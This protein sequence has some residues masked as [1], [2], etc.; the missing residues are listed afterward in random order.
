M[1][2]IAAHLKQREHSTQQ[3]HFS[4]EPP[5]KKHTEEYLRRGSA[6]SDRNEEAME[7]AC[8]RLS[9]KLHHRFV[10]AAPVALVLWGFTCVIPTRDLWRSPII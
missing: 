8:V 7:A 5:Q 3:T 1:Q 10:F 2:V 9:V 4:V 6:H